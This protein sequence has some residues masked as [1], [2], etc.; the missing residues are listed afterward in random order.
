MDFLLI[1]LRFLL[2]VS[3]GEC[4][5]VQPLRVRPDGSLSADRPSAVNAVR[6]P[7]I[8]WLKLPERFWR[9]P[10]FDPYTRNGDT[11]RQ[12]VA[13]FCHDDWDEDAHRVRR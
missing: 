3:A 12:S 4:D 9:E 11:S 1:L 6:V 2:G 10:D 8:G 5:R 7:G 13:A